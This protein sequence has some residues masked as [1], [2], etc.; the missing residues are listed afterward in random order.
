M[1]YDDVFHLLNI[2]H[3]DP[4]L[5]RRYLSH[6]KPTSSCHHQEK[7]SFTQR[8]LGLLL[9]KLEPLRSL[10]IHITNEHTTSYSHRPPYSC[11]AAQQTQSLH[12]LYHDA[13]PRP[14]FDSSL[15]TR[16][17]CSLR[18]THL[19]RTPLT[20]STSPRW[21]SNHHEPSTRRLWWQENYAKGSLGCR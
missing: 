11:F 6:P 4:K 14:R 7:C 1:M 21:S 15:G 12:Y 10:L 2:L 3:L 17:S 18:R 13:A 16:S 9:T 5:T 20:T 19:A 8:S